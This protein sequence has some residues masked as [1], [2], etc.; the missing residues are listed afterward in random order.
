[1]ILR[2]VF[3]ANEGNARAGEENWSFVRKEQTRQLNVRQ[4]VALQII[5]GLITRY[6][7]ERLHQPA[8]VV[9]ERHCNVLEGALIILQ[10]CLE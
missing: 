6:L 2:I 1:M 3:D 9:E 4:Q 8:A 7:G 5:R 10:N